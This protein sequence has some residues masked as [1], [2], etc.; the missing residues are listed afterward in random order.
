MLNVGRGARMGR[1]S[2]TP[3]VMGSISFGGLVKYRRERGVAGFRAELGGF[4]GRPDAA[5]GAAL[6]MAGAPRGA[7]IE[8]CLS[9][10]TECW[11]VVGLGFADEPAAARALCRAASELDWLESDRCEFLERTL[12]AIC[13]E[14]VIE[15]GVIKRE[16]LW[17]HADIDIYFCEQ[18]AGEDYPPVIDAIAESRFRLARLYNDAAFSAKVAE[19]AVME[20]FHKFGP[21]SALFAPAARMGM[22]R[23]RYVLEQAR[24]GGENAM[25]PGER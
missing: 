15:R 20:A 7:S 1:H 12:C 19:Y 8:I 6:A 5:I 18:C 9:P 4:P 13:G 11:T 24:S 23:W 10:I 16:A 22:R 2:F 25:P 21:D 14:A 3:V 17:R